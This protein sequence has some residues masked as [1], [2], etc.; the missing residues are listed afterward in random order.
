[1]RL[2][3]SFDSVLPCSHPEFGITVARLTDLSYNPWFADII[4]QTP[5]SFPLATIV[6]PA[7]RTDN[8]SIAAASRPKSSARL[9]MTSNYCQ[10]KFNSNLCTYYTTEETEI[11]EKAIN[12]IVGFH[13][14]EKV[15]KTFILCSSVNILLFKYQTL[16][17]TCVS[18]LLKF[19]MKEDR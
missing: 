2:V 18:S 16:F 17:L 8:M 13:E 10:N 11:K 9:W 4:T 7:P 19:A 5:N 3:P 12:R 6:I 1:M 14:G 15:I